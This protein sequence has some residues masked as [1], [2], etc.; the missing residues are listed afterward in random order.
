MPVPHANPSA[1][2]TGIQIWLQGNKEHSFAAWISFVRV[3]EGQGHTTPCRGL[4]TA[5]VQNAFICQGN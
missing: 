3:R 5:E 4:P 2:R 1:H